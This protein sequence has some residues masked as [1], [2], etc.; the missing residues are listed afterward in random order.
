MTGTINV[1]PG[2][3]DNAFGYTTRDLIPRVLYVGQDNGVHEFRLESTGWKHAPLSELSHAPEPLEDHLLK[4]LLTLY[5]GWFTL[6][7]TTAF[8]SCGLKAPAG[9][10]PP[11]RS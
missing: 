10:T 11:S 2:A 6:A 5:R 4:S 9:S 7:R 3:T 1:F 8:T